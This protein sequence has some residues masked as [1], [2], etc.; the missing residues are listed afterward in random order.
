MNPA[1][2]RAISFSRAD[3]V[4]QHFRR[5]LDG[6]QRVAQLVRQPRRKLPQRGQAVGARHGLL[7]LADLH[8]GLGQLLR[9]EPVFFGL[10]AQILGQ[11]VGQVADHGQENHRQNMMGRAPPP[12][13]GAGR[14]TGRSRWPAPV[15]A[16]IPPASKRGG[17]RDHRQQQHHRVGAVDGAGEADKDEPQ[18]DLQH[19]PENPAAR[20]GARRNLR[21][22]NLRDAQRHQRNDFL[23]SP[24]PGSVSKTGGGRNRRLT[25]RPAN[26]S[27][28]TKS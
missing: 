1:T 16:S 12:R 8:V 25:S 5:R 28:H 14:N 26:S 17:G 21:L 10:N 24:C 9:R 7:R 2:S 19:D 15:N 11:G 6:A 13:G 20:G 23:R 4:V 18:D 22:Q 27:T 3:V